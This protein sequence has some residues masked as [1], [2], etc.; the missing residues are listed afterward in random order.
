MKATARHIRMTPRKVSL[1]AG[2]IRNKPVKEALGILKFTPRYAAERLYKALYSAA[3]NAE[4]NDKKDLNT[5]IV[6]EVIIN[7][8]RT[9]KRGLPVSK[10]RWHRILKR[11][12]HVHIILKDL[13]DIKVPKKV[14]KAEEKKEVV[15]EKKEVKKTQSK[16]TPKKTTKK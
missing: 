11:S 3:S 6:S 8:G 2:L 9:L 12:S 15:A 14:E 4:H 16:K 13:S 5:L 1:V 10:G 7:E